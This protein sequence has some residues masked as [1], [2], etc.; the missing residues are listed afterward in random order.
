MASC[1]TTVET[2]LRMIGR[3]R[4]GAAARPVDAQDTLEALK[5][6]YRAWITSGAFGRL[7]DVMPTTDY[8]AGENQRIFRREQSGTLQITLPAAVPTY[9]RPLPYNLE[10]DTYATNYEAVDGNNR[11]PRDGAVVVIVDEVTGLMSDF[12]YDGQLRQWVA[13]N[14]DITVIGVD[15]MTL[16]T[17]APLSVRDPRG[18]AACLALEIADEYGASVGPST[19][20]ASSRFKAALMG[21]FSNP[22]QASIGVYC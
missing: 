2:A 19:V 9:N 17:Q 13:V 10:R 5:G 4:S 7:A 14:G 18:L 16:D 6:L 12:I 3:L 20:A 8:T 15:P 21:G 22:R 11:P 1:R